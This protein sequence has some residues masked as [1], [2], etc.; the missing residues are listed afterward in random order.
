VCLLS[1]VAGWCA[2][3]GDRVGNGTAAGRGKGEGEGVQGLWGSVKKGEACIAAY[4]VE[5]CGACL[6]H[7]F[8]VVDMPWCVLLSVVAAVL[9][10]P[11]L[12][13]FVQAMSKEQQT[14]RDGNQTMGTDGKSLFI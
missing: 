12:Y 5:W 13:S 7:T 2:T 6:G 8:G 14:G 4:A 11:R 3:E 10:Q 1:V 9:L